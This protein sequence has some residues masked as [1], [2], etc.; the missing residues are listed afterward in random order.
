MS[1]KSLCALLK[2][3]TKTELKAQMIVNK[4][5]NCPYIYFVAKKF[6]EVHGIF[7]IPESLKWWLD[8]I[9]D[10]PGKETLGLENVSITY[11]DD[12]RHPELIKMQ[13]PTK[14]RDVAPCG[15]DCK[16]CPQYGACPGCP[17]TIYFKKK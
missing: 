1:E 17:A 16:K 12:V 3:K 2:G 8:Y 5:K 4:Y 10:F 15:S 7:V 13:L 11:F 14:L 9:Q 6:K